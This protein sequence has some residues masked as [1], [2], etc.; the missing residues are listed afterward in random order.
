MIAPAETLAAAP[1][2]PTLPPLAIFASK[3]AALMCV[4]NFCVNVA[5]VFLVSWLPLYLVETYGNYLQANIGDQQVVSGLMTALTGLA[6]MIGN[7]LGGLATDRLVVRFG[8]I[9]GR[10]LPGLIAGDRRRRDLSPGSA[11]AERVVVR[12]G[13]GRD[14]A[15]DRLL[16]GRDVGQLPGHRRPSRGLGAGLRQHVRQLWRGGLYLAQRTPRRP[17]RM[18]QRVPALSRGDGHRH[19]E[20]A[21]V[22]SNP[23]SGGGR[24]A[25]TMSAEARIATVH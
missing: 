19:G 5:W 1:R 21:A 18:E 25:L 15:V 13:D 11:F 20:L 16:P 22:R 7:I 17:Q 9:W 6:G 2:R 24:R 10:R 14:F 3:E 12:R 8:P 23:A 4:I